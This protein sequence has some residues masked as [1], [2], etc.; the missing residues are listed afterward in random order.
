MRMLDAIRAARAA[1][2]L[3]GLVD[4]IPYTRFMGIS[5]DVVQSEVIGKLTYSDHL[6]GNASVPALHGGTIGALLESTAVFK[7]LW[8]AETIAIPKTI[9]ITVE[10][11]RTGKPMDTF[12]RAEFIRQGRR[13]ASVRISAYQDE[14]ERPIAAA[15]AHFLLIRDD[16]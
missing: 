5:M 13:V 9:N 16:D 7:L 6:I 3:D 15:N 2:N 8:E 4:L 10:Y 14:P 1:D 12:A 11:L